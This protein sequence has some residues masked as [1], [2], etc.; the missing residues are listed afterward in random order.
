MANVVAPIAGRP[1][2]SSGEV[3]LRRKTATPRTQR[4]QMNVIIISS[5]E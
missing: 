3:R 4:D 1:K 2:V 5:Q